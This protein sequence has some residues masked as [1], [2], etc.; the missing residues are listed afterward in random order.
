[1]GNPFTYLLTYLF[2]YLKQTG[3]GLLSAHQVKRTACAD[4]HTCDLLFV[5]L[6]F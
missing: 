3:Q 1:M 2:T 5:F 6:P 4:T